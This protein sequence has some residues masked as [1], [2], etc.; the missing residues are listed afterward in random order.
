MFVMAEGGGLN[1]NRVSQEIDRLLRLAEDLRVIRDR[2][3]PTARDLS[4]APVLNNWPREVRPVPCLVGYVS[5]HPRLPGTGRPVMTSDLW[6]LSE[7]QGW[8]RALSRW[9]LLGR[10]QATTGS[11][12]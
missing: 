9:Y 5:D 3:G 7:H 8:A 11:A 6:V 10:P 12:S 1:A 4:D 2:N